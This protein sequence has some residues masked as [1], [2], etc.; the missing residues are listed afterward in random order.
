MGR[1]PIDWQSKGRGFESPQLHQQYKSFTLSQ[2]SPQLD[3]LTSPVSHTHSDTPTQLLTSFVDGFVL[4]CTVE[5]KSPS[6]VK[7]YKGILEKF[8]WYLN[9]F[10]IHEVNPMVIRGFLGYILSTDKR[11]GS[12]NS[13]ANRRVGNVTAQ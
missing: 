4:T 9:E 5:G 6:T 13:R 2:N 7:F 1:I 10:D 8:I 12:T 3:R 11:W